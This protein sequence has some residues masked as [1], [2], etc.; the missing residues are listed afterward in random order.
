MTHVIYFN[1]NN[2]LCIKYILNAIFYLNNTDLCK[3]LIVENGT[4]DFSEFLI[5]IE[6]VCQKK[7]NRF[8]RRNSGGYPSVRPWWQR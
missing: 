2:K 4:V 6:D 5:I 3:C 7:K 8:P 1:Q